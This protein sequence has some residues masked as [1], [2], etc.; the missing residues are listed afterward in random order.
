M[1]IDGREGSKLEGAAGAEYFESSFELET[2]S[3][4]DGVLG[5]FVGVGQL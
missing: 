4:S 3:N 2:K 1:K 5:F